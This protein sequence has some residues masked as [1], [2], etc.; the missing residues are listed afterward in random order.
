[1]TR[2]ELNETAERIKH[3]QR[4]ILELFDIPDSVL[5]NVFEIIDDELSEEY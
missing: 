4:Q 3:R 2:E 1:M 5:I